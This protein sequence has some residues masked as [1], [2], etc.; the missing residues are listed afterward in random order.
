M[1]IQVFYRQEEIQE[2]NMSPKELRVFA[3]DPY[4]IAGLMIPHSA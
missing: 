4:L 2:E 3:E 1:T